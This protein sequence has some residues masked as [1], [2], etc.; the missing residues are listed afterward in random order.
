MA[1]GDA[2]SELG[3]VPEVP[4]CPF[5]PPG[6]QRKIR[7]NGMEHKRAKILIRLC[8]TVLFI[9]SLCFD[10]ALSPS[11]KNLN[12][13][14]SYPATPDPVPHAASYD[15]YCSNLVTEETAAQGNCSLAPSPISPFSGSTR[16]A[17]GHLQRGSETCCH[18]TPTAQRHDQS[19]M[20]K[21]RFFRGSAPPASKPSLGAAKQSQRI[22]TA[23]PLSTLTRPAASLV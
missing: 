4:N 12:Q 8:T 11:T 17:R 14:N 19:E 16:R 1:K 13:K 5:P 9:L 7:E 6:R 21:E 23:R 18:Q 15:T 20:G 22:S 2:F 3:G 10:V